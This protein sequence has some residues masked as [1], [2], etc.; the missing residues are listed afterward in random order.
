MAL[1][2][3][4]LRSIPVTGGETGEGGGSGED[5]GWVDTQ[6]EAV[7][8]WETHQGLVS[9][10][11]RSSGSKPAMLGGASRRGAWLAG[12]RAAQPQCP[13]RG[14]AGRVG[15][16]PEAAVHVEALAA[17]RAEGSHR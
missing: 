8:R 11:M 17:A 6:I 7:G 9:T 3:W 4:W 12:Q 15:R 13:A 2:W 10:T 14:G 5:A 1:G 16:R